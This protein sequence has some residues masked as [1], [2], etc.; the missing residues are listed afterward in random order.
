MNFLNP[1]VLL[2]LMPLVALPLLIHLFNRHFPYAVRFPNIERIKKSLSERSKL[3]RWRH[4]LM[5]LLRTI[6][7]LLALFAFLK[8]VLPKFGS[9]PGKNGTGRKIVMV[10]DRSLSLEFQSGARS[11][12]AKNARIEIGKILDTLNGD[13]DINVVLAGSDA[14]PLLPNFTSNHTQIASQIATLPPSY[15]TVNVGKGIALAESLLLSGK[16]RPESP[17]VYFISDF[18]RRNWEIASFENFPRGTRVF[19]INATDETERSNTAF[20]RVEPSATH[21]ASGDIVSL[22]ITVGNWSSEPATIPVEA[23]ID[24]SSSVGD[25]IQHAPYSSGRLT[26]E[27][28]VPGEGRHSIAIRTPDDGLAADNHHFI[29]LQVRQREQVLVLTDAKPD[30][31]GYVFVS[32]ALNPNDNENK[33]A[34]AFSPRVLPTGAVTPGD[35]SSTKKIIVTGASKFYPEFTSRLVAFVEG[36]GGLIYF[37][38]GET[39]QENLLALDSAAGRPIVPFQLAGKLTT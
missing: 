9:K 24:N 16:E 39:D 19:F 10:L 35:I 32:A 26:L 25:E 36:G 37:L 38:D 6:I 30:T 21:V 1:N 29:T 5:T 8:P 4:I 34:G 11:S 31:G 28:T 20:V 33:E 14:V 27:F 22:D 23:V 2:A 15:E 7:V 18:Q 17:E 12:A 3:A 13:D